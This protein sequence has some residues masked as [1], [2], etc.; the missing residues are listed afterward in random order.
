[1][2]PA[3]TPALDIILP[4][5]QSRMPHLLKNITLRMTKNEAQEWFVHLVS[6]KKYLEWGSGG[7]TEAA[8]WQAMQS[9][10]LEV[11]SVEGSSDWLESLRK[12]PTA[13]KKAERL[14]RL[15]MHARSIGETGAWGVPVGWTER[16]RDA[17]IE[18]A[19]AYVQAIRPTE[20][21][22][23]LIVV[24]GRFREACLMHALHL[25]HQSTVVLLH[26][27]T[28]SDRNYNFTSTQ[29]C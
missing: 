4:G 26:D 5:E 21:C 22:Y 8:A 1:M 17:R 19:R 18:Q 28:L 10:S 24:D 13:L 25:S 3:L 9:T 29:P 16:E 11:D 12:K 23:D 2:A 20:C 15:R 7:S 6:A 27:V 14:G